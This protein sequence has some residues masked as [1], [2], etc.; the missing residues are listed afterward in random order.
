MVIIGDGKGL[1]LEDLA[2]A[3]S[4]WT[5]HRGECSSRLM[6]LSCDASGDV[7]KDSK[8]VSKK[9]VWMIGDV[10]L[11]FRLTQVACLTLATVW[12]LLLITV[13]GLKENAWYLLIIGGLGM[14]QNMMVAG[15]T[16][17]TDTTG[18]HLEVVKTFEDGKVMDAL[19]DLESEYENVGKS[20]LEEFFP[21]KLRP[22]ELNWWNG[23][24]S[25]YEDKR[26]MRQA[27]NPK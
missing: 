11:S 27:R 12:I 9:E 24:K 17:R 16:R 2:A 19:M 26:K 1:D 23:N 4:P 8:G 10:P 6:R 18:I 20:L 25:M 3:E 14:I 22:E 5:R 7:K 13:A 21:G 15:A